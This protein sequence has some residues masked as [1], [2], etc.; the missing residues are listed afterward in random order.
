MH[1]GVLGTLELEQKLFKPHKGL[2]VQILVV[3]N[4]GLLLPVGRHVLTTKRIYKTKNPKEEIGSVRGLQ[5][6]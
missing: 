4:H 1:D 6:F 3:P 2:Q 5:G